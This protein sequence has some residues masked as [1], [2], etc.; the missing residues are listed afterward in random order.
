[1][2]DIFEAVARFQREVLM[3]HPPATP[4]QLTADRKAWAV[5]AFDEEIREFIDAQDFDEEVDALADLP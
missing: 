1:M 2:K 3:E 5:K 4:T